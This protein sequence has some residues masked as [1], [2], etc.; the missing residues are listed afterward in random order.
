MSRT[1]PLSRLRH[2]KVDFQPQVQLKLQPMMPDDLPLPTRVRDR[3]VVADNG[4]WLWQ[5]WHNDQ[6][7]PYVRWKGKDTPV[8]RVTVGFAI[9]R[10][11]EKGEDADHLCKNPAC[12]NPQHHEPVP[13]KINI[14]RSRAATKMTCKHGHDW[15]D[16]RNV[17]VRPDGRRWCAACNRE[18]KKEAYRRKHAAT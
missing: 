15:T 11:L 7:Y 13:H 17:L 16:P 10:E 3:I 5:G 14:R 1:N 8:H 12:V 6:G 2:R 18:W 4:C 9:G